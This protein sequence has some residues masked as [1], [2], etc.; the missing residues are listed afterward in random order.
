[1]LINYCLAFLSSFAA[2]L[3]ATFLFGKASLRYKA[4]IPRGVPLVGGI[5]IGLAFLLGWLAGW[6]GGFSM[7]ARGLI[8]SSL[9]MLIFGVIDDHRELSVAAKLCGQLIASGILILSGIQTH[10]VYI[11]NIAN[12]AITLIWLLGISN[13]FNHLDVIDGLAAGSAIIAGL[14]FFILAILNNDALTA[15][16]TLSLCAAALSFLPYNL[17]PAKIYMGNAGSHFLGFILAASALLLHYAPL[18]RKIALLSPLFVLGFPIFDTAFLILVRISKKKLPFNK[19]NDH[20]ALKLLAMGYSKKKALLAMLYFCFF[21]SLCGVLLSRAYGALG[22]L[23]VV[24]AGLVGL[25][26][27]LRMMRIPVNE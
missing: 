27:A 18:E 26:L 3:A 23:L 22:I 20:P 11:G 12:I 10:I 25:L 4:F 14:A 15:V 13:A 8:G 5:A 2:G 1:M 17:P 7:P 9:I 21:F 19:S 6:R 24:F 16:I